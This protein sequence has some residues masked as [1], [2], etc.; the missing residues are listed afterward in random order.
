MFLVFQRFIER[1]QNTSSEATQKRKEQFQ[2]YW[3]SGI[4]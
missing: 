2:D 1:V 3:E 4:F